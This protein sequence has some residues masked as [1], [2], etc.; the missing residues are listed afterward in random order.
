VPVPF[1]NGPFSTGVLFINAAQT[2]DPGKKKPLQFNIGSL[3]WLMFTIGMALAYLRALDDG[4]AKIIVGL[5]VV[6]M[7]IVVGWI[8]GVFTQRLFTAIYWSLLGAFFAYIFALD[9]EPYHWTVP[10]AWAL[11]GMFAGAHAG[12][13]QP[14]RPFSRMLVGGLTGAAVMGTYLFVYYS[15]IKQM[16]IFDFATAVIAGALL[17]AVVE[18]TD[19]LERRYSF[20][21]HFFAAGLMLAVILA[22]L[23]LPQFI[24]T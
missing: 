20:S 21:H 4:I 19:W 16:M 18:A 23:F 2:S 17:A 9:V 24:D 15:F 3:L 6:V 1:F 10:Y 22:N 8:V 11:V 14:I 12:V 7:A 13:M 5:Q